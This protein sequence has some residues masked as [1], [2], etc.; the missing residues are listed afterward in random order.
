MS[1]ISA[2]AHVL[3]AAADANSPQTVKKLIA[4]EQQAND[5][6]DRVVHMEKLPAAAEN[7]ERKK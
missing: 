5:V 1:E 6:D 2:H 3:A 4:A 7:G